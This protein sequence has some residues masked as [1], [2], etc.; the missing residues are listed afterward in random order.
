MKD[1]YRSLI[2]SRALEVGR[3]LLSGGLEIGL[4]CRDKERKGMD[5]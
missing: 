4:G 5:G 2:S 1:R 3:G